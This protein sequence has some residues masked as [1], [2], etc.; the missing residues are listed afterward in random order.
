VTRTNCAIALLAVAATMA[1]GGCGGDGGGGGYGSGG[2][3]TEGAT[4]A[5]SPPGAESG[6]AVLTVAGASHVGPVLVDA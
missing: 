3:S 1:I 4:T 6:V 5:K 2:E